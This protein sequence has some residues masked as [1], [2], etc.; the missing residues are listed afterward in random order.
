MAKYILPQLPYDY[1]AFNG[2]IS[3]EIMSLHHSKH[4]QAY[5]DKLNGALEGLNQNSAEDLVDLLRNVSGL[6]ADVREDVVNNGGG[7]YNH[8]L[9]W[10]T[11]TPRSNGPHG[12]V[13][14]FIISKYGSIQ[15]FIDK[16]TTE[17]LGVFGSGWV[18]LQPNGDI[19]TTPNQNTPFLDGGEEPVFGLDVWEHAYYLDYKNVRADYVK[20]WWNIVNW[21]FVED[22]Y[23]KLKP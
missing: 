13:E 21:D 9:F 12:D 20:A 6:P 19:I 11:L 3:E 18:W 16:F 7:H 14:K 2:Y 5:V 4:H 8:S 23:Q 17:A 1:S 22:R 15:A 10:E